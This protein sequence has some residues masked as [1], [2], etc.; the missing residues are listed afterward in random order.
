MA[1]AYGAATQSGNKK[2]IG[3]LAQH[4]FDSVFAAGAPPS[5]ILL[6]DYARGVVEWANHIGVPPRGDL[7]LAR[8]PYSS[9]WPSNPPERQALQDQFDTEEYRAIWHSVMG[10]GDF[11]RHVMDPELS[12]WVNPQTGDGKV[13]AGH[14]DAF[15]LDFA[16]RWVFSRVIGLGWQPALFDRFDEM[17]RY[18]SEDVPRAERVGKKYQ[19]IAYH[20]LLGFVSDHFEFDEFWDDDTPRYDGPWN[21]HVRD[22][23]PTCLLDGTEAINVA[24]SWVSL[25]R[26]SPDK[27]TWVSLEDWIRQSGGVDDPPIPVFHRDPDGT[28]WIALGGYLRWAQQHSAPEP[29]DAAPR[30]LLR[31]ALKCYAVRRDELEM[32][33]QW[34]ARQR[35]KGPTMLELRAFHEVFVREFPWAPSYQY[36]SGAGSGRESWTEAWHGT[37]MPVP[38]MPCVDAYLGESSTQDY[39]VE[40]SINLRFPAGW[41]FRD[42]DLSYGPVDGEFVCAGHR[43]SFNPRSDECH[44]VLATRDV[45]MPFL[46]SKGLELLWTVEGEKLVVGQ[47][48]DEK[49]GRLNL[50]GAYRLR[51]GGLEGHLRADLEE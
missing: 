46:D 25:P 29:E 47:L 24:D 32:A 18:R 11:S 30:G 17:V 12:C 48:H 7:S 2:A 20:E 36:I 45:L 5:H 13:A 9:Q 8:P 6:R 39:S 3:E 26:Y 1:V 4:I 50:S 10:D 15:D 14:D 28:E 21:P 33:Y 43:F 23:D 31:C 42:L 40:E 19:W 49:F 37:T 16:H 38:V 35:F 22:I 44:L 51:D 27:E 34:A 41:I